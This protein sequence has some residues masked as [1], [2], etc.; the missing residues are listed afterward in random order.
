MQSTNYI[1]DKDSI[2][3]GGTEES[4][5]ASYKLSD[6]MGEIGTGESEE[7]CASMSFDGTDDYVGIGSNSMIS[8][9]EG[10][11]S[12][13]FK[14]NEIDK[15][16]ILIISGENSAD[17]ESNKDKIFMMVRSSDNKIDSGWQTASEPDKA[18][19]NDP[20]VTNRWYNA[21]L[22]WSLSSNM[23]RLYVNGAIQSGGD[24]LTSDNK[25]TW[26]D[27][28]VL[29]RA[30]PAAINDNFLD[31]S[32]DDVR[33]YNRALS[34]D[35]VT[36]L[37]NGNQVDDTGLVGYWG[38][39]G[40]A[41]G[42][43]SVTNGDFESGFTDGLASGWSK[44]GTGTFS[45]ETSIAR[46]SSA[47]R[48]LSTNN[49]EIYQSIRI[50][51]GKPYRFTSWVYV[52]SALNYN[53]RMY[54]VTDNVTIASGDKSLVGEWQK[55][56]ADY[57]PVNSGNLI[58]YVGMLTSGGT[59]EYVVDDV[60]VK[61]IGIEDQSSNTND[62]TIYG[63]T[64]TTDTPSATCSIL[65]AGYRQDDTFI[66][67]ISISSPDDV[68]L[69]PSFGGILGGI[70]TG[71]ADWTVTTDDP[72][73]Y[74][75]SIKATTTPALIFSAYSF[76]DYMPGAG[77]P[78]YDWTVTSSASEF[79]YSVEGTNTVSKFL[80]NGTSCDTGSG[81]ASDKCW[82]G[83]STSDESVATSSS[84]NDPSGTATTIKFR[85]E[86]GSQRMQQ[87]GTYIATV[88]VTAVSL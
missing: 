13:W 58:F 72:A 6:T 26:V 33:I 62:G 49:A 76:A 79:G 40:A 59:G 16:Q 42:T 77:I 24:V 37:Y 11:I 39:D 65:N 3:F 31:G 88:V 19:S 69:G 1:I 21:T 36:D 22:I 14:V 20:V 41:L 85:A 54:L 46:N 56:E 86:A 7:K 82:L 84:S 66:S 27:A 29:G 30:M 87:D 73:G 12:L 43:D 70:G 83:F 10:T 15:D 28:L 63:A 47:Q 75:V 38:F 51:A 52:V 71:S 53:P 45:Q 74:Q 48:I 50:V 68:I 5:S 78:D 67:T 34:A 25:N 9:T 8:Q 23:V 60:S 44:T 57:T 64:F 35:E 2:N 61:E 17:G 18:P 4:T 32:V 80:D 55:I 81:N